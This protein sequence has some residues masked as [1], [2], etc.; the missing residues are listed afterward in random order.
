MITPPRQSKTASYVRR[1][2]S[3]SIGRVSGWSLGNL[4]G[5]SGK[6][7]GVSDLQDQ[8][9]GQIIGNSKNL[10][11]ICLRHQDQISGNQL[12][13]GRKK[14]PDLQGQN[15]AIDGFKGNDAHFPVSTCSG[16]SVVLR[17]ATPV[18]IMISP[19]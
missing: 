3:R 17:L 8:I 11:E 2:S 14:S 9:R 5:D 19:G 18:P 7:L 13:G 4:G 15:G 16:P 12:R 1:I 10:S 6:F